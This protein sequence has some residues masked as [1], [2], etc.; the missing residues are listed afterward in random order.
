MTGPAGEGATM[1]D[2]TDVVPGGPQADAGALR[3]TV[4]GSARWYFPAEQ[5]TLRAD[6][7][8]AG[9]ERSAVVEDAAEAQRPLLADVVD[10][11]EAG[12]LLRHSAGALRVTTRIPVDE[13][14]RRRAPVHTARLQVTGVFIDFDELAGFVERWSETDGVELNVYGWDVLDEHRDYYT[15]DVRRD[16]VAQAVAKAQAFADAVSRGPVVVT[17]FADPGLLHGG[18][19]QPPTMARMAA[20]AMDSA[21]PGELVVEPEDVVISAAV[22]ARFVAT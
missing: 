5:V 8:F 9:P 4:S 13:H 11:A 1:N 10:L 18:D 12:M 19:Q 16:A 21:G 22:E 3:I 14:G 17:E 7:S 2:A 20:T 6:I 15:A